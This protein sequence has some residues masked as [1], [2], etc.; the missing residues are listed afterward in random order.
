MSEISCLLRFTDHERSTVAH[1]GREI[2]GHPE[3][4]V[5]NLHGLQTIIDQQSE[6]PDPGNLAAQF[7]VTDTLH[8]L[9][10]A[11]TPEELGEMMWRLVTHPSRVDEEIFDS[12][13]YHRVLR[14][15]EAIADVSFLYEIVIKGFDEPDWEISIAHLEGKRETIGDLEDSVQWRYSGTLKDTKEYFR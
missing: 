14:V 10:M 13:R 6:L 15:T 12:L 8:Y 11:S 5:S 9:F 3:E 4:I 2:N 1:V 7:L